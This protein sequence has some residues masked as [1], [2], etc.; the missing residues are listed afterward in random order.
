MQVYFFCVA[1]FFLAAALVLLIDSLLGER[2]NFP[3][4][5]QAL[6]N[7]WAVVEAFGVAYDAPLRIDAGLWGAFLIVLA[8]DLLHA[9]RFF[10]AD[11]EQ[12]GKQPQG[13]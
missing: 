9:A 6:A 13:G 5:A 3:V 11:C 12:D 7:V 1:F 10:T 8:I 2:V 4:L